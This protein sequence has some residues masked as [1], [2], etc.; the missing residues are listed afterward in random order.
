M[1]CFQERL[2][3]P[4]SL[5]QPL[6]PPPLSLS[7]LCRTLS[8]RQL[9]CV[10]WGPNVAESCRELQSVAECCRVLQSVAECGIVLQRVAMRG[11][12]TKRFKQARAVTCMTQH[13]ASHFRTT[14]HHTASHWRTLDSTHA[15]ARDCLKT[16]LCAAC[17]NL[18]HTATFV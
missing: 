18:L 12:G 3:H 6:L 10:A 8:Y 16:S 1:D 7:I 4:L 5:P 15:C 14:L 17:N 13:T 2:G 11:I 9:A